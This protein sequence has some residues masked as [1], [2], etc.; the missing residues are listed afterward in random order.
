VSSERLG[1]DC[2]DSS[3]ALL[4]ALLELLEQVRNPPMG[5]ISLAMLPTIEGTVFLGKAWQSDAPMRYVRNHLVMQL[6]IALLQLG[7][8]SGADRI[9][10]ERLQTCPQL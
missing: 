3:V 4:V 2:P 5:A 8:I 9:G 10:E 1:N 7:A 6:I